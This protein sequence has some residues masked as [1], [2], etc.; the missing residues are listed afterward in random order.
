MRKAREDEKIKLSDVTDELLDRYAQSSVF[1][2]NSMS[3]TGTVI[4][5]SGRKVALLTCA[6][7][8]GFPDTLITYHIDANRRLTDKVASIAFKK[9]QSNYVALLPEGGDM[10]I[11]AIDED[12]DLA[13]LLAERYP[14][15]LVVPHRIYGIVAR[16][17]A[18][19]D[20]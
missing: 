10:G 1:T 6:H 17:P 15:P 3:G 2:N 20:A 13:V 18:T 7:V 8:V 11:L 14:E 16:K 19:A 5:A 12:A 9:R 4:Y